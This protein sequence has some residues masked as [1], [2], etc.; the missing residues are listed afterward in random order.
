M[1]S[2]YAEFSVFVSFFKKPF[3]CLSQE[4]AQTCR[5]SCRCFLS[6]SMWTNS[7]CSPSS[8]HLFVPFENILRT[9]ELNSKIPSCLVTHVSFKS[10]I[11]NPQLIFPHWRQQDCKLTAALFYN[12]KI[13]QIYSGFWHF[14]AT[15]VVADNAESM[16]NVTVKVC[17]FMSVNK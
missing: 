13:L 8:L 6:P 17:F 11:K 10:H 16:F 2:F 1:A 5:F 12:F 15:L 9:W 3:H 4:K 7:I 14:K